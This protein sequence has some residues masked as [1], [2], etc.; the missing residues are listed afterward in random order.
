MCCRHAA[1]QAGQE[2]SSDSIDNMCKNK[3]NYRAST[4]INRNSQT[5]SDINASRPRLPNASRTCLKYSI[6]KTATG[7][8]TYYYDLKHIHMFMISE[9]SICKTDY[10]S[11]SGQGIARY[12]PYEPCQQ[13][14]APIL[15]IPWRGLT[16]VYVCLRLCSAGQW[17][18]CALRHGIQFQWKPFWLVTQRDPQND[19]TAAQNRV[20]DDV[21]AQTPLLRVTESATPSPFK[22]L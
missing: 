8:I 5:N 10:K 22:F 6:N 19:W 9:L 15:A 18:L 11:W 4:L 3:T 16:R 13:G 2:V 20:I 21:F 14:M 12:V 17:G 1:N 7:N